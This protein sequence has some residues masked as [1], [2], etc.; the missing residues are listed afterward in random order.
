MYK[1]RQRERERE[2]EIKREVG[3]LIGWILCYIKLCR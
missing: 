2:R 3:C 1:Y